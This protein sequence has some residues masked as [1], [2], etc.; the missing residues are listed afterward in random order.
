[1]DV[2]GTAM[3]FIP[4]HILHFREC[5]NSH[6]EVCAKGSIEGTHVNAIRFPAHHT[7][8]EIKDEAIIV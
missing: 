6:C 4:S 8:R 2:E 3:V 5:V 1:M 7:S